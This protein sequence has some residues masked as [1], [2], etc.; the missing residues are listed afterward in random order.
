MFDRSDALTYS[1][2]IGGT[3]SVTKSGA[4][5]LT[6]SG[7]NTYSGGTT[8]SAGTLAVGSGGTAGSIAGSVTN[9]AA[10]VFNRSDALT[11]S[12][13]IGGTGSVTK[14]GAGTLTLSGSNTYSGFTAVSSGT[15][16]V[17]S[18]LGSGS[19]SV[20]AAAWLMGTG[21]INGRVAVNGTLAPGSSPGVISLG[22]LT[23]ADT[24]TTIIEIAS[25]GP[26]G[27]AYD[28]IS[29]LDA[30]GLTYG[31]TVSLAFGGSAIANDTTFDILSFTGSSAG[32]LAAVESSG[33]YAGTWTN[34]GSGTFRLVS[35]TQTLTFSQSTG[36]VI[37]VPEPATISL[38]SLGLAALAVFVRKRP[39]EHSHEQPCRVASNAL[40]QQTRD[41]DWLCCDLQVHSD[42]LDDGGKII[43]GRWAG[44]SVSASGPLAT[45]CSNGPSSST[46][47]DGWRSRD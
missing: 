33:F 30:N 41:C 7:S 2:S 1:G 4:G 24:S 28:G 47:A 44:C 21:T 18:V 16:K 40:A 38:A 15:L 34:L 9:N 8:I 35:G 26:R 37:V 14:S 39:G 46:P 17:N 13:S 20:A 3:G 23:L 6:L 25:A 12:G 32:A 5:T 29:I 45:P 42:S 22:S 11:Y 31:G 19:L 27:T 10:L 43:Q 36:D